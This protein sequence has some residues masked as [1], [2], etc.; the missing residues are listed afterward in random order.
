MAKDSSLLFFR[1]AF[2]TALRNCN[3][4]YKDATNKRIYPEDEQTLR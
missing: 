3:K 1:A 2:D 4:L